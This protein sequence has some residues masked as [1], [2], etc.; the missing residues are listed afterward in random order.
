[1]NINDEMQIAQ[2]GCSFFGWVHKPELIRILMQ[3]FS[4]MDETMVTPADTGQLGIGKSADL[5]ADS[6]ADSGLRTSIREAIQVLKLVWETIENVCSISRTVSVNEFQFARIADQFSAVGK[7]LQDLGLDKALDGSGRSEER[8]W[9]IAKPIGMIVIDISRMRCAYGPLRKDVLNSFK[10]LRFRVTKGRHLKMLIDMLFEELLKGQ[11]LVSIHQGLKEVNNAV[12]IQTG[13]YVEKIM[14]FHQRLTHLLFLFDIF[15]RNPYSTEYELKSSI[16]NQYYTSYADILVERHRILIYYLNSNCLGAST[17]VSIKFD[18]N[19]N[20]ELA[21]ALDKMLERPD[22]VLKRLVIDDENNDESFLHG[23]DVDRKLWDERGVGINHRSDQQKKDVSR[24]RLKVIGALGR[25]SKLTHFTINATT[26]VDVREVSKSLAANRVLEEL[27]LRFFTAL[28]DHDADILAAALKKNQSVKAF[29][30]ESTGI[31]PEGAASFGAMLAENSTLEKLDVSINSLAGFAM[32]NLLR[33]LKANKDG[34][35]PAN[36]SL[37]RLHLSHN[38]LGQLMMS[39]LYQ[40]L[41]TNK[42][43]IFFSIRNEELGAD[44][45]HEILK[46]LE[47]NKTLQ[48]LDISG[49]PG[50]YKVPEEFMNLLVKYNFT[51]RTINSYSVEDFIM[52]ELKPHGKQQRRHLDDS[53][54]SKLTSHSKELGMVDNQSQKVDNLKQVG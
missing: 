13:L 29:R 45:A 16:S 21:E 14:L 43:L 1:M 6:E 53:H 54:I 2:I 18:S 35:L 44:E 11:K 42:T 23:F 50:F 46:S 32:E 4:Q 3:F 30:L 38:K 49:C 41:R 31:S 20:L 9:D 48:E 17:D 34:E 12:V 37:K 40:T 28:G 47:I 8:F 5:K 33:P 52:S 27:D 15:H 22:S 51:L 39:A 36:T 10:V 24:C 25:S 26:E 7:V 19:L